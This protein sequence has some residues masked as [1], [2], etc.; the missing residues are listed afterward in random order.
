L[1]KDEKIQLKEKK[2]KKEKKKK[3]RKKKKEKRKKRYVKCKIGAKKSLLK[4]NF[5]ESSVF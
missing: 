1:K 2:E 5:S 4:R 3:R